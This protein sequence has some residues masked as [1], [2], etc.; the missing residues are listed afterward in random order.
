MVMKMDMMQGYHQV[1]LSEDASQKTVYQYRTMLYGLTCAPAVF[2]RLM[3]KVLHGL[4]LR[5][6]D[7]CI[8]DILIITLTFELHLE[9]LQLVFDCLRLFGMLLKLTKCL[10]FAAEMLYLGFI[11]SSEGLKL[12]PAKL[13]MIADWP[14]PTNCTHQ[15]FSGFHRLLQTFCSRLFRENSGIAQGEEFGGEIQLD[16]RM[17]GGI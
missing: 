5:Y 17:S 12:E 7:W 10:F 4:L 9:V 16:T 1:P 8:D 2:Q 3:S 11:I 15:F 13:E 14:V 6:V